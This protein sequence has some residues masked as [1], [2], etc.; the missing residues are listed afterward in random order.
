MHTTIVSAAGAVA[1]L[2][3]SS[4]HAANV[5]APALPID[6]VVTIQPYQVCNDA[7][8]TCAPV[9]FLPQYLTVAN[10][11]LNQAGIAVAAAPVVR[12]NAGQYLNATT[13][14]TN[15]DNL[16]DLVRLPANAPAT[17]GPT[18]LNVWFV[19]T[20]TNVA[21]PTRP[22]S[23][24]GFG[25]IGGNG[26]VLATGRDALGRTAA[27]DTLAHELAHNLGLLHPEDPPRKP[28]TEAAS[29]LPYRS[30]RNL[31]QSVGRAVVDGTNLCAVPPYTC[32]TGTAA[33]N[34]RGVLVREQVAALRAPPIFRELPNMRT[35][36]QDRTIFEG[37]IPVAGGV[38]VSIANTVQASLRD[39]L[40]SGLRTVSYRF[41]NAEAVSG[42][43]VQV[44]DVGPGFG[45]GLLPPPPAATARFTVGGGNATV[46]VSLGGPVDFP[47]DV[48]TSFQISGVRPTG[49]CCD[50]TLPFSSQYGFGNGLTSRYGFSATG[51]GQT[52]LEV[53][54]D[55]TAPGASTLRPEDILPRDVGAISPITG[56]P[57]EAIFET[58]WSSPRDL[59]AIPLPFA[60]FEPPPAFDFPGGITSVPAPGALAG[61]GLGLVA[62][63]ALRR[64]QPGLRRARR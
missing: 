23:F 21:N 37:G 20:L 26:A 43:S 11:L 33:L 44:T 61:F 2:A 22:S 56:L 53:A 58:N 19:N 35:T 7:G 30:P 52:P 47:Y 64:P 34:S 63:A 13:T 55:P 48:L 46:D 4:A 9:T 24:Y 32:A 40:P 38:R 6:R 27:G 29:G 50:V 18:T 16:R 45:V 57:V 3:G 54:F 5:N 49:S 60:E 17:T 1:L 41:K 28:V 31:M 12:L 39:P 59:A 15:F 10:A 51:F 25:L 62:L 14:N 8:S 36:V 42:L